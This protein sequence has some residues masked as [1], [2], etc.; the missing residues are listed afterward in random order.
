MG[1]PLWCMVLWITR[2]V[3]S[4]DLWLLSCLFGAL[5]ILD[6]IFL[7]VSLSVSPLRL[8]LPANNFEFRCIV[9]LSW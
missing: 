1:G 3:T 8:T 9:Q 7:L 4:L 6:A 5:R 2:A